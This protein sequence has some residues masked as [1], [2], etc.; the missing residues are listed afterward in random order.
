MDNA[1][2]ASSN[3]RKKQDLSLYRLLTHSVLLMPISSKSYN[4]PY[5]L[6]VEYIFIVAF[7]SVVVHACCNALYHSKS[8][9]SVLSDEAGRLLMLF[10]ALSL[11]IFANARWIGEK[12]NQESLALDMAAMAGATTYFPVLAAL[13]PLPRPI[14]ILST[15]LSIFMSFRCVFAHFRSRM[16]ASTNKV[17]AKNVGSLIYACTAFNLLY[18]SAGTFNGF[19]GAFDPISKFIEN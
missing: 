7:L 9:Y 4:A 16:A 14:A 19:S 2:E 6:S 1:T 5:A 18:V 10:P 3:E 15:L 13:L 8:I 11:Q 12:F 17:M